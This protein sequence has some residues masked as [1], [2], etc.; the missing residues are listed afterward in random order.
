M[1]SVLRRVVALKVGAVVAAATFRA[2]ATRAA[3]WRE[4]LG[5]GATIAA[6]R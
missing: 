5:A 2:G 4:P 1:T 6:N 3:R